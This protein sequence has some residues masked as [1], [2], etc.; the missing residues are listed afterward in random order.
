MAEILISLYNHLKNKGTVCGFY[1][2]TTPIYL[3]TDMQVV[4]D[5]TVKSFILFTNR[6]E[7]LIFLFWK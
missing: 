3:V 6:S 7:K 1:N 4:K 5:I 2:L